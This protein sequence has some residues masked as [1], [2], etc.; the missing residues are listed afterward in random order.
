MTTH[1][2]YKEIGIGAAS[3]LLGPVWIPPVIKDLVFENWVGSK[4]VSFCPS[5]CVNFCLILKNQEAVDIQ[6][7]LVSC[8]FVSNK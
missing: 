7:L 2:Y 3:V 1:I 8:D 6:L 5:S 4:Q